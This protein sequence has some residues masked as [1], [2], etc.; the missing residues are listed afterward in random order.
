VAQP[1]GPIEC[2][3]LNACSTRAMRQKLRQ[4]GVPCVL[5]WQTPV[6]DERARELC[7]LFFRAL[8]EDASGARDYKRAFLAATDALRLQSRTGGAA[9][10]PRGQE[11]TD[12]SHLLGHSSTTRNPSPSEDADMLAEND[13][14]S[15]VQGHVQVFLG[16][17]VSSDAGHVEAL[18]YRLKAQGVQVWWD[19]KCLDPGQPW[20][21]GFA[22]GLSNSAIFVPILS[23]AALAPC[24][25]LTATSTTCDN[26]LLEHQMAMEL[27]E[28][29]DIR[30]IFP[31]LVGELMS[32]EGVGD[33]IYGDFFH[34]GGM[35]ACG[36]EVV[37]SVEA[38]LMQHLDRLGKGAPRLSASARTV[39][40][41]L[42]GITEYQRVKLEGM[43]RDAMDKAV[44]GI[45]AL[46]SSLR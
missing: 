42:R 29:G 31:V 8:V 27:K 23:M 5:C 11:A 44:A 19:A 10:L 6:Q 33:S 25:L 16:Y 13:D 30:A 17:R 34:K 46:A 32:V 35:P 45:V 9:H 20:E 4:R 24:A 39:A 43:R 3:V 12:G 37:Q 15:V 21:G 22:D 26:V 41:T 1:H 36:S 14:T 2:V 18:Y 38:K 40:Q 7:E 28:R